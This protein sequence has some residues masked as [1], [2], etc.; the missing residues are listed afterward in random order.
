MA[1]CRQFL[2]LL[3]VL[4]L[5]KS[6]AG[7]LVWVLLHLIVLGVLIAAAVVLRCCRTVWRE[8][9]AGHRQHGWEVGTG[10]RVSTLQDTVLGSC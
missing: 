10:H 4:K 7:R 8:T 9:T 1:V 3:M 5:Q 2:L 6:W